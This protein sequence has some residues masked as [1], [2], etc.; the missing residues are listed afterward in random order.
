MSTYTVLDSET[1]LGDRVGN[2]HMLQM[3]LHK[4]EASGLSWRSIVGK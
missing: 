1:S 3:K 4:T 2:K